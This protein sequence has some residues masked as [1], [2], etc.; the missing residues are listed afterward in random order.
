MRDDA[1]PDQSRVDD[2]VP[3][4]NRVPGVEPDEVAR[5]ERDDD[6]EER[7]VPSAA[8]PEGDEVGGGVAGG[9]A[10]ERRERTEAEGVPSD[11]PV[12]GVFVR[13]TWMPAG[14]ARSSESWFSL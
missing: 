5:E 1:E 13:K 12:D 14:S 11:R 9:D 8:E 7:E 10:D 2:A 3:A 6:E 4:E